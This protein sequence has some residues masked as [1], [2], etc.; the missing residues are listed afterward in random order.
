MR[1][2]GVALLLSL[3]VAACSAP[4]AQPSPTP[5]PATPAPTPPP[6][7]APASSAPAPAGPSLADLARAG[8]AA[9]YKVTY[10]VSS[11]N[12]AGSVEGVT[13][14]WYVKPP[15]LRMD[16]FLFSTGPTPDV[17][18]FVLE[19]GVFSCGSSG[20]PL[21][22]I[23]MPADQAAQVRQPLEVQ[24]Q[25]ASGSA[26]VDVTPKGSRQIAGQQATCFEM[27]HRTLGAEGTLCYT[28]QGVALLIAYKVP[29]IEVSMEATA[30]STAV[31]DDDFKLPV[32]AQ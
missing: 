10:K 31:S 32:P 16:S 27:R 24:S 13:Q 2:L 6:T 25:F 5:V 8:K 12:A 19:N 18:V 9:T 3:F 30:Y 1:P 29:G 22:C 23:T 28:A 21:F 11:K 17:S 15:K 4:A 7:P 20:G 14:T 26:D